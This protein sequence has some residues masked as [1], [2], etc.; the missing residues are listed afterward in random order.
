M[1]VVVVRRLPICYIQ[2]RMIKKRH[3]FKPILRCDLTAILYFFLSASSSSFLGVRPS[4]SPNIKWRTLRK[5]LQ[6]LSSVICKGNI[7]SKWWKRILTMGFC[8]SFQL[9]PH[10]L[11]WVQFRVELW[12]ESGYMSLL[13]NHVLF[14]CLK[15]ACPAN[16][17]L[18]C[19]AFIPTVDTPLSSKT[20]FMPFATLFP[21]RIKCI[22]WVWPFHTVFL[23]ASRSSCWHQQNHLYG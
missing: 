14:S 18:I 20:I 21:P 3:S 8:K 7:L 19:C 13:N 1:C 10:S 9:S 15:S 2:L 5:W 4:K 6:M 16:V 22:F 23:L 11:Y 12:Q 17:S